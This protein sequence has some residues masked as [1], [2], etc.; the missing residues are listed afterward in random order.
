MT[1]IRGNA[2]IGAAQASQQPPEGRN[3]SE[4]IDTPGYTAC[5]QDG[6]PQQKERNPDS[7]AAPV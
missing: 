7:E 1:A 4:K 3:D 6:N 5:Q 2:D